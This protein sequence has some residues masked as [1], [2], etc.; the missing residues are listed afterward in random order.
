MPATTS[1]THGLDVLFE[2]L[3]E[4][5]AAAPW[6]ARSASQ[7]AS[8]CPLRVMIVSEPCSG[9]LGFAAMDPARDEVVDAWTYYGLERLV[10]TRARIAAYSAG[11]ARTVARAAVTDRLSEQIPSPVLLA[12]AELV[13]TDDF[14]RERRNVMLEERAVAVLRDPLA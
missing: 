11:V 10:A 2:I 4:A 9:E 12:L 7:G 6:L 14:E 5:L 1:S 3:S 8:T 13:T